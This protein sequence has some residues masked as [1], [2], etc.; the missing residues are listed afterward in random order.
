[1]SARRNNE[2]NVAGKRN[3]TKVAQ[4]RPCLLRESKLGKA[5]RCVMASAEERMERL[6]LSPQKI[7]SAMLG[8]KAYNYE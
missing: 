3:G 2:Q 1:M 7:H 8:N 6:R 5:V 4:H